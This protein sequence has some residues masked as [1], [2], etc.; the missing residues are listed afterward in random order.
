MSRRGAVVEKRR[1]EVKALD[2]EEGAV[3]N[4]A[5]VRIDVGKTLE[6]VRTRASGL[7]IQDP[8]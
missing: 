5:V 6:A 2:L 1:G 4:L 8:A 7:L 3:V